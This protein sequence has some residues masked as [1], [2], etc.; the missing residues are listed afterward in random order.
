MKSLFEGLWV[1]PAVEAVKGIYESIHE[2]TRGRQG[3]RCQ[4]FESSICPCFFWLFEC[5]KENIFSSLSL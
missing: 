1:A 4:L 5:R 3:Q 2:R